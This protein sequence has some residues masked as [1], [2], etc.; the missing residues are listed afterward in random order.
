[1][2]QSAARKVRA[3]SGLGA[4]CS[5]SVA[6]ATG[7]S[8]SSSSFQHIKDKED[9]EKNVWNVPLIRGNCAEHCCDDERKKR[10]SNTKV[11]RRTNQMT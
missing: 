6:F 9:G 10:K 2:L 4:S 11:S 1:M 5:G 8:L 7:R 3:M